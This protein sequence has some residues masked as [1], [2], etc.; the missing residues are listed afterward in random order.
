MENL[1]T[2]LERK[3]IRS[4]VEKHLTDQ[5]EV[6]DAG[7]NCHQTSLDQQDQIIK[8]ANSLGFDD[9]K[10]FMII[11]SEE[12]CAFGSKL[13]D[14]ANKVLIETQLEVQ[15]TNDINEI[16]GTII[17]AAIFIVILL[18]IFST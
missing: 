15:N 17:G 2:D 4:L 18:F 3:T 8:F 7:G 12:S 1:V 16:I 14:D 13:V 10:T 5:Q 6:S 11:Y 9:S